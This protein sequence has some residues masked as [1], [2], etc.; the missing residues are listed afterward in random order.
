M[1]RPLIC[2]HTVPTRI[3]RP[4][5][6]LPLPAWN[7]H[8]DSAVRRSR[9]L[10]GDHAIVQRA[11]KW[12]PTGNEATRVLQVHQ[13]QLLLQKRC[14]ESWRGHTRLR[15]LVGNGRKAVGIVENDGVAA[16]IGA[17]GAS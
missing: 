8:P 12:W 5:V 16:T 7:L 13:V 4:P 17:M 10:A 14:S 6:Y 15:A 9:V 1:R 11:F 2:G 3:Y